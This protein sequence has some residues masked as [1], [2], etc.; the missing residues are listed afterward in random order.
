MHTYSV[1]VSTETKKQLTVRLFM[2]CLITSDIRMHLKESKRWML[3]SISSQAEKRLFET[4]F[5]NKDYIGCFPDKEFLTLSEI[6]NLEKSIRE[7]L[8][9]YCP[10]ISVEDL[11]ILLFPQVFLT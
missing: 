3:S 1:Y 11:H 5:Q 4:H 7:S 10:E 9:F 2:G 6:K 8:Q